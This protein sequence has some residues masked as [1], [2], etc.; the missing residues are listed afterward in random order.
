MLY[1]NKQRHFPSFH[2]MGLGYFYIE[3]VH[4]WLTSLIFWDI[5]GYEISRLLFHKDEMLGTELLV[6]IIL[7]WG[8]TL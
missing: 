8:S 5:A 6:Y 7:Q 4:L 2:V 3:A 1:K